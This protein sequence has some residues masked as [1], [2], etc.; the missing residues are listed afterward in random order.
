MDQNELKRLVAQK[1]VEVVFGASDSKIH[2]GVGTGSTVD[3]FIEQLEPHKDRIEVAVSSSIRS[4][5]LLQALD[6]DVVVANS[7]SGVAVYVDGADEV[8]ST[9]ALT[10]GGGGAH[11][12]EKI[13]ASIADEFICIVDESK[14]VKN[15]G[16]FPIPVEVIQSALASVE[17]E[18]EGIGGK[19]ILR[20]GFTTDNGHPI[21]DVHDLLVDDPDQLETTIN[22]LPGVVEVGIFA[23]HRPKRVLVGG[24]DGAYEL[25]Q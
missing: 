14:V 25:E 23:R 4:R 21:L 20:E 22:N 7:V 6:I 16:G 18:I 19:A 24:S 12:Q 2:L 11:T 13:V 9:F 15:L 5:K 8:D 1:T 3:Q 17:R 10:K